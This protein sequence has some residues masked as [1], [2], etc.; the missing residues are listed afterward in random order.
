MFAGHRLTTEA[1][2]QSFLAFVAFSLVASSVYVINDLADLD[3]DRA[4][5]R[6]RNRPFASGALSP[7]QGRWMAALLLLPGFLVGFSI[8]GSFA[9]VLFAYFAVTT[10]YSF[11]LKRK[12]MIDICALAGLYT[13]RIFAGGVATGIT[14]SVW[15]LAFSIF[16]FF[17]LAAVKRQGE[18]VD[19]QA[20]GET[21]AA[22]RGYQVDDLPIVTGMAIAAGYLS[23]LVMALY[24]NSPAVTALYPRPFALWGVCLVLL[25]WISR[26]V[27]IA[28]RGWMHDDPV[29]FAVSDR[30]SQICLVLILGCVSAG[31]LP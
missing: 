12:L 23:V 20:S 5:P 13:L 14:L 11:S 26:T 7:R 29:I 17:A 2:V 24:A 19:G 25:Y 10:L 4:H 15:L 28:H 6:K 31:S 8:S 27:I 30:V 9:L 22:G 16:F 18:L 21:K 3:A 1:A